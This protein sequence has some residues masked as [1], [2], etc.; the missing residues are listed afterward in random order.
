MACIDLCSF[1]IFAVLL[2]NLPLFFHEKLVFSLLVFSDSASTHVGS[3]SAQWLL[4][5]ASTG[6]TAL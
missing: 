1:H 6:H 2:T 5:T 3:S 4:L